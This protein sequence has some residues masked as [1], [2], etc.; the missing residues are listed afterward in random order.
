[1]GNIKGGFDG[2]MKPSVGEGLGS[3]E[4]RDTICKDPIAKNG[5]TSSSN[6]FSKTI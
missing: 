4:K 2:N 3:G 5:T 1:M 6:T